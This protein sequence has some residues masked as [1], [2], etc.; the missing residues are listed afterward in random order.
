MTHTLTDLNKL[1]ADARRIY[2][3]FYNR[4]YQLY[5]SRATAEK[6]AWAA[7]KRKYHLHNHQ[8]VKNENFYQYDT[9]PTDTDSCKTTDDSDCTTTSVED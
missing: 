3:K 5:R 9:T 7:V 1:P 6:I 2:N 8:W 4:T